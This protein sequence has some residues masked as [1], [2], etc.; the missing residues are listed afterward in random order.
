MIQVGTPKRPWDQRLAG[1][2]VRPLARTAVHPNHVTSLSLA[3]GI[4]AAALFAFGGAG[5]AGWAALL[6]MMAV[7]TD[8]A[9]GELARVKGKTSR[10]GHY[11]DYLVGAANYT[12]LFIAIGLGLADAGHGAWALILGAAAGLANPVI[13]TLRL[14]MERQFGAGAVRHPSAAGFE[15]EDMIYLIGPI[16]WAGGLVIF[17]LIFGLGTL[18]YLLWTLLG[19]RRWRRQGRASPPP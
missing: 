1:L 11:Y 12:L 13:V 7:F 14:V 9:D 19:F 15:L 4:A 16:T 2:I 3:F 8:H 18:G 5:A 10:F 6:F 17:F